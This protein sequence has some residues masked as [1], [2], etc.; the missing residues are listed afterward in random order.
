MSNKK[1]SIEPLPGDVVTFYYTNL[2]RVGHVGFY[3]STDKHKI[4]ALITDY[5]LDTEKVHFMKLKSP[6]P[7]VQIELKVNNSNGLQG[8]D[9]KNASSEA[10]QGSISD[11]NSKTQNDMSETKSTVLQAQT[12]PNPHRFED[13]CQLNEYLLNLT[14]ITKIK[15]K[16]IDFE[17]FKQFLPLEGKYR[18]KFA[19]F[20]RENDFE[21]ISD[22][23]LK[24]AKSEIDLKQSFEEFAKEKEIDEEIKD[25]INKEIKC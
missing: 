1:T 24:G 3:E 16:I 11:K 23:T 25:I 18:K 19:R 10:Q 14:D 6:Y 21:L 20:V 4:V 2:G 9:F 5:G 22:K 15:V 17:S 8:N 13:I 12:C 7:M